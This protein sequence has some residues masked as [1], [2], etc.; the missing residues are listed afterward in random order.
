[1]DTLWAVPSALS[2]WWPACKNTTMNCG[3]TILIVPNGTWFLL[4]STYEVLIKD[5][6]FIGPRGGFKTLNF[7]RG[8]LVFR[9]I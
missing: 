7:D 4:L 2:S 5:S 1:M 3:V 9:K 8:T 6:L